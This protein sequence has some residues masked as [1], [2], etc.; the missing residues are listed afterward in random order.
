MNVH[1]EI[2]EEFLGPSIAFASSRKGSNMKN[3]KKNPKETGR[4]PHRNPRHRL[5]VVREN[6][7]PPESPTGGREG[8]EEPIIE[9]T[10]DKVVYCSYMEKITAP[11]WR[12]GEKLTEAY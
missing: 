8:T 1:P 3:R 2:T 10:Q 7:S 9:E 6:H 4:T 5:T 11:P 12:P